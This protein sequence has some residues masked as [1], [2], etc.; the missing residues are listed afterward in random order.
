MR[1]AQVKLQVKHATA[2][3][4]AAPTPLLRCKSYVCVL[5][6]KLLVY[7]ALSY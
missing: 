5:G 3:S 6:L 2:A 7:A 4:N 1:A